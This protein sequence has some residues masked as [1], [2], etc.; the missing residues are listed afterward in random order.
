MKECVNPSP[1]Y[2]INIP[3]NNQSCPKCTLGYLQLTH[4]VTWNF[5]VRPEKLR[6]KREKAGDPKMTLKKARLCPAI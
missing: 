1:C 4:Q 3:V 6:Q 5:Q 2:A